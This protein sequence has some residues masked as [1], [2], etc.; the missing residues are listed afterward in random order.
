MASRVTQVRGIP[1]EVWEQV[2]AE[3][4]LLGIPLGRFVTDA[5]LV[6]VAVARKARGTKGTHS[7]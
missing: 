4:I 5:L 7:E 6:A 3:A 2:K 1:A